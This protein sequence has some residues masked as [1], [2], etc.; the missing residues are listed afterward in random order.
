VDDYLRP[1]TVQHVL[2]PPVVYLTVPALPRG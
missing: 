1:P 2:E